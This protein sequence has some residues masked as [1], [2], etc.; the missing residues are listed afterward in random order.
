V[1]HRRPLGT[2]FAEKDLHVGK[3]RSAPWLHADADLLAPTRKISADVPPRRASQGVWCEQHETEDVFVVREEIEIQRFNQPF[4]CRRPRFHARIR[5]QP[6]DCFSRV[7]HR[8]EMM[9]ARAAMPARRERRLGSGYEAAERWLRRQG[10]DYDVDVVL[11]A[12]HLQ[13]PAQRALVPFVR[14]ADW[15]DR[16]LMDKRAHAPDALAKRQQGLR[17]QWD[18]VRIQLD[19]GEKEALLALLHDRGEPD[20]GRR[21]VPIQIVRPSLLIF[22]H[23]RACRQLLEDCT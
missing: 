20:G 15:H 19:T 18:F 6:S 11:N 22:V 14:V 7:F 16:N 1:Q 23:V 21:I 13:L 12:R 17:R 3:R 2:L 4:A 9:D 5:D 8:H 10:P